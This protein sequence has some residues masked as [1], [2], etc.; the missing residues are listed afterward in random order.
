MK[1]VTNGLGTGDR[2]ATHPKHADC[3]NC[4]APCCRRQVMT[5][6]DKPMYVR[7][8]R[9]IYLAAGTNITVKGWQQNDDGSRQPAW[10]CDAFDVKALMCTVY[11]KR[12]E[13]CHDYDCREDDPNDWR[14]RAH[15]DVERHRK[16]EGLRRNARARRAG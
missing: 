14:S 16:M 13:H 4:E 5:L 12:P 10:Q 3:E 9:P 7:D 8:A 1:F 2:L 15:C 11:E 6:D